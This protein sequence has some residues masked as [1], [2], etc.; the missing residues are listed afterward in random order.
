M[1]LLPTDWSSF[2]WG[3]AVGLFAAFFTGFFKKAGEHAYEAFRAK[4]FPPSPEPLEVDRRFAPAIFKTG[5]CSWVDEVRVAEFEDKGFTH[6]PHQSG[7][8][9]CFRTSYDGRRSFKEFLMV[10]PG[11]ELAE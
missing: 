1:S 10:S 4:A 11:A 9:K 8:P 7:A 6:Y 5:G 2:L 3:A